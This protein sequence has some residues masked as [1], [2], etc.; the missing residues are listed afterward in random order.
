M[1]Y[2]RVLF[3][4]QVSNIENNWPASLAIEKM[5]S[6]IRSRQFK[7]WSSRSLPGQTCI[8][9]QDT[10]S[11]FE[12]SSHHIMRVPVW[13]SMSKSLVDKT[14]I[15]PSP[16]GPIEEHP[17]VSSASIKKLIIF[18][19]S[20]HVF[21]HIFGWFPLTK[22]TNPVGNTMEFLLEMIYIHQSD[23]ISHTLCGMLALW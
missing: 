17:A 18:P 3:F 1:R 19:S 5:G 12:W 10:Y 8:L 16:Y 22:L 4:E 6:E 23:W 20:Q 21:T 15:I 14:N 7:T 13:R 2:Y 9:D 11:I